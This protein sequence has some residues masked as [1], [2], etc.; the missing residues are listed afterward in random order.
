MRQEP[1]ALALID[2]VLVVGVAIAV[3]SVLTPFTSRFASLGTALSVLALAS[4]L[5]N[6]RGWSWRDF[7]LQ[8]PGSLK[9]GIITVGQ[10]MLALVCLVIIGALTSKGLSMFLDHPVVTDDRFAGIE[11]NIPS[12]IMWLVIGWVV[13]GFTEEMVFRGFLINR[14]EAFLKNEAPIVKTTALSLVAIIIPAVLFGFA[15]YWNRGL[16]GA[17]QII[18]IGIGFGLF[19]LLYGRRLLPLILAHGTVDTLGITS[20]FLNADW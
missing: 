7:G 17:L 20:R 2:V 12:Y 6:H 18:P 9:Q 10:A 4:I 11:G 8:G 1:R 19:Y 5:I 3:Q 13:G 16:Y 15:H 14:V